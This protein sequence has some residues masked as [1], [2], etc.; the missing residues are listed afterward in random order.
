MFPPDHNAL[1]ED[2]LAFSVRNHQTAWSTDPNVRYLKATL[3]TGE[4][5]GMAKWYLLLDPD[6]PG[7]PWDLEF[8]ANSNSDLCRYFFGSLNAAREEKLKGQRHMLMAILAVLPEY[9]RM[10]IGNKLL[11]W[12][13]DK[14]DEEQVDCWIDASPYGLGLYKKFGWKEVGNLDVELDKWGG[15]NGKTE[16][17]VHMIRPPKV[18]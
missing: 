5:I 13:L 18:L 4:I 17:T 1:P 11:K 16:R 7:N 6:S 3:P 2:S 12:G 14:A 10:G 9:Q 8:P 15:E